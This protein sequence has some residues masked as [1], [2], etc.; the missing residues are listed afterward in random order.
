MPSAMAV[1]SAGSMTPSA[2]AGAFPSFL[3]LI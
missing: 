2:N 3:F 1:A